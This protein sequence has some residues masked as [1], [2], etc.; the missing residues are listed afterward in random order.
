MEWAYLFGCMVMWFFCGGA[1]AF[2]DKPVPMFGVVMAG[3]LWPM[4]LPMFLGGV[5]LKR[6]NRT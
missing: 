3:L 5:V 6:L 2:N 4:T 1:A